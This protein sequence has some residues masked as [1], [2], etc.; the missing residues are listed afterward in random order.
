M[1]RPHDGAPMNT[2]KIQEALKQIFWL[3]EQCG[4]PEEATTYWRTRLAALE[5]GKNTKKTLEELRGSMGGMSSLS[6]F[7]LI[8]Y[9]ASGMTREQANKML[10]DL[11]DEIYSETK[12]L[13]EQG[14]HA[15][16]SSNRPS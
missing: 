14:K 9:L 7:S 1:D 15:K 2:Q 3:F 10:Q 8:P 12:R 5:S 4:I 11:T 6:D 13:L 16:P